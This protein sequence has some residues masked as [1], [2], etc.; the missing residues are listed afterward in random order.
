METELDTNIQKK[1]WPK[2]FK[3]MMLFEKNMIYKMKN[4]KEKNKLGFSQ[5]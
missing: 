3:V 1:T 5:T 2:E 4:S